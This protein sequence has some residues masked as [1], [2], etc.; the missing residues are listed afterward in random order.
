VI[1][2]LAIILIFRLRRKAMI[3]PFL[4]AG[5]LL[6]V[7]VTI[8]VLGAH[9]QALRLLLFVGWLRIVLK[10][11]IPLPRLN[12]LDKVVL[13]YTLCNSVFFVILAPTMSA[14]NNRLGYLWTNLG[15]YF[16]VRALIRDKDDVVRTIRV[17]AILVVVIA[18]LMLIEHVTQHNAFFV[19]GAQAISNIRD[20]KIR[21]EGPF[22]HSIIAGTVG[23]MLLPLFIGLW[24]Q[25]KRYRTLLGLGV[26]SSI[27]MVIASSSSTPLMTIAAGVFALL[28]WSFRTKMRIFRW[29]LVSTLAVLQLAM[30]S[31]VWFLI[32][33]MGGAIGGSGYHRAQL[34]DTFVRHFG[35]WWLVGTRNNVSWGYDMWD[36]DNAYVAAGLG[37]GLVTF[38]AFIAILVYAYKRIGKSGRLAGLSSNDKHLVWAIGA[39]LFANTVGF[40]GI[41]YF[42]QGILLWYTLLAMVTATAA[43]D[44]GARPIVKRKISGF[45]APEMERFVPG[46][47]SLQGTR[48]TS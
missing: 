28:L 19:V 33:R 36:V 26:A 44:I 45:R 38:I 22:A 17:L 6:P 40:F 4:A 7:N 20:G 13:F 42:D 39:S 15:T 14:V 34:I 41:F 29:T 24:W 25:G 18:P 21:A 37:G 46:T 8:V 47:A 3:V 23:G 35:E 32:S 48:Y 12:S 43:F 2:C 16:L 31:P 5:I 11:D 30:K 10:R 27:G 1:L 9:F